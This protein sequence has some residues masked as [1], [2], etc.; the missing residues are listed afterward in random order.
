[1]YRAAGSARAERH[2]RILGQEALGIAVKGVMV[3]FPASSWPLLR[4]GSQVEFDLQW[5]VASAIVVQVVTSLIVAA[6]HCGLSRAALLW[7]VAP[8][9]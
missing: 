2:V 4:Y 6:G 9:S 3:T 5:R 1:M 8:A 7:L